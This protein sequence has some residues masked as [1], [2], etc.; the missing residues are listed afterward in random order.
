MEFYLAD[1]ETERGRQV[2]SAKLLAIMTLLEDAEVEKVI[3]AWQAV[4]TV[5]AG[6]R[7][8]KAEQIAWKDD[9]ELEDVNIY[10][11]DSSQTVQPFEVEPVQAPA[12]APIKP[13][14]TDDDSGGYELGGYTFSPIRR[15]P[16]AAF[17]RALTM[18]ETTE[19][20][21]A[22]DVYHGQLVGL[23]VWL[24]SLGQV[25][26]ADTLASMIESRRKE[27]MV[28][29]EAAEAAVEADEEEA[30]WEEPTAGN[31]AAE[32]EPEMP[33]RDLLNLAMDQLGRPEVVKIMARH[34]VKRIA[35]IKGEIEAQMRT[36]L[37][38]LLTLDIDTL[39][40]DLRA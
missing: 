1:L 18:I 12:P 23:E 26:K 27:L 9:H 35:E 19:N 34:G 14:E 29:A 25:E 22:L 2:I 7:I 36:A 4:S 13:L 33:I 3:R 32:P 28:P 6:G 24:R 5:N 21:H 31:G 16:S 10:P 20:V 8:V 40:E 37:A 39:D 11:T 15:G 38:P 30:P 17:K